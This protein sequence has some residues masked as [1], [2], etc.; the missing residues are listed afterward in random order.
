MF[1]RRFPVRL[2][3]GRLPL[4]KNP[5]LLKMLDTANRA[6]ASGEYTRAAEL[7]T[8]LS[9]RGDIQRRPR[10]VNWLIKAGQANVL[11]GA[12]DQGFEQIFKGFKML[13]SKQRS[14]DLTWFFHRTVYLFDSKGMHTEAEKIRDWVRTELNTTD[15]PTIENFSIKTDGTTQK[16]WPSKCPSCGAPVHPDTIEPIENGQTVCGYCGVILPEE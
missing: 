3:L 4:P 16:K 1:R 10:A 14:E 8:W 2:P 15:A 7:F 9:Q 13:Q 11:N 6:F 5:M 12:C